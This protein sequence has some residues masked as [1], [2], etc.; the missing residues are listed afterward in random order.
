[1]K[2]VGIIGY[3]KSGKTRLLV[4][5]AKELTERGYTVSSLKHVSERI[6][7]ADTDTSLHKQFTR[8]TAA[9]SPYESAVFFPESKNVEQMLSLLESDFILIEGFKKEKTYPKIICLKPEDDLKT[10]V[11]GLQICVYGTGLSQ[12][13]CADV[14]IF[15]ESDISKIA[16]LVEQKA[17]KLPNLNCGGC[18]YDSCYELAL[19]IIKGNKIF[20]D[21]VSLNADLKIQ[22]NGQTIPLNPFVSNLLTNTITA[23]LSSLKDYRSG[24]IDIHVN[25]NITDSKA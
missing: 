9:V 13:L 3:K 19:E 17:F 8:Q 6:D 11:D 25:P 21:C 14:P 4:S 1:L 12:D 23:M 22:I 20:D 24:S 18:G 10:L 7:I 15:N 16:D 5:L 2:A